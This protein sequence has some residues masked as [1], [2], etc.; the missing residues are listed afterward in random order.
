MAQASSHALYAP[1]I[2]DTNEYEGEVI[3][4]LEMT[5]PLVDGDHKTFQPFQHYKMRMASASSPTAYGHRFYAPDQDDWGQLYHLGKV[6]TFWMVSVDG[7]GPN[8]L[9]G[10]PEFVSTPMYTAGEVGQYD[11]IPLP[12]NIG[13]LIDDGWRSISPK[14]R[15]ELSTINSLYELKDFAETVRLVRRVS[16]KLVSP[17]RLKHLREAY[18]GLRTFA[19][20]KGN[21]KRQ[22]RA[23][24]QRLAGSFLQW[25]FAIQPLISDVQAV[26]R[27]L[28][29]FEKRVK[30]N[31]INANKE[32]RGHYT[33]FLNE[34]DA[35][36]QRI[37]TY[38]A[39]HGP[40]VTSV[41]LVRDVYTS[42]TKFHM[43]MDYTY[44]YPSWQV[45]YAQLLGLLDALGI[46]LNP[47]EIVW[48]AL[49]FTFIIDWVARVGDFL[50]R[51]GGRN[52]KPTLKVRQLCWSVSRKRDV[53]WR[54]LR[55][56]ANY[57]PNTAVFS[58]TWSLLPA[59]SETA[60]RRGTTE[61]G[62]ISIVTS[63]VSL[64][65]FTLASA[66]LISR[67]RRHSA[68]RR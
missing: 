53:A 32:R 50:G 28:V 47:L 54:V 29:E 31:L 46:Q 16:S 12:E 2:A 63:G 8:P 19:K 61:R 24:I 5:D 44:V 42:P 45:E 41:Q 11:F 14:V 27:A 37:D 68:R 1:E 20:A 17:S 4:S 9:S 26:H 57:P 49:P 48:N 18:E 40:D 58:P 62:A 25:K 22:A 43:M 21:R 30:R 36:E 52:M 3:T 38:Q 7:A 13:N 15:D 51:F 35:Y 34:A 67:G 6:P 23:V 59:C 33:L 10:L 60:F 55:Q 66:L 39:F 56:S 64:N 65:E